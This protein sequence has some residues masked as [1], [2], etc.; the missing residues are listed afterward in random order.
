[1]NKLLCLFVISTLAG[2]GMACKNSTQTMNAEPCRDSMRLSLSSVDGRNNRSYQID[3]GQDR[4]L[5]GMLGLDYRVT[6]N[7]GTLN[8]KLIELTAQSPSS[9]GDYSLGD[10][11]FQTLAKATLTVYEGTAKYVAYAG[12]FS[13]YSIS[14]ST[15]AGSV[16]ALV[17]LDARPDSVNKLSGTF[18]ARFQTR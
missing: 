9:T 10:T 14:D 1:M 6:L 16:N 17:R 7:P 5:N 8:A 3:C 13:I 4:V 15:A 11:T 2:I 12:K 18:H